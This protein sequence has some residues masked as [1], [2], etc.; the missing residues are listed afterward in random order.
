MATIP[1]QPYVYQEEQIFVE[2]SRGL[3]LADAQASNRKA[4]AQES[5]DLR[6]CTSRGPHDRHHCHNDFDDESEVTTVVPEDVKEGYSV[7]FAVKGNEAERFVVISEWLS[8]W[9]RPRKSMDLVRKVLLQFLAG[10]R[11]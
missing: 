9:K 8:Y 1:N 3:R 11:N 7:V 5:L 2:E 4:S 6:G 10:P